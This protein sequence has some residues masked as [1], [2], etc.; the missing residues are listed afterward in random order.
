MAIAGEAS[1]SYRI[2]CDSGLGHA[3]AVWVLSKLLLSRGAEGMAG[4]FLMQGSDRQ[5]GRAIVD[6]PELT[7][8]KDVAEWVRECYSQAETI[9][10]YG[11]GGSTVMAS[12]MTGKTIFS[13]ESDPDWCQDMQAYFKRVGTNSEVHL[14][15]AD[16]GPVG[17]W[18]RPRSHKAW[19][20]YHLYPN[21]VW[22][23]SDFKAPDL[24]LVD[25]RFRTACFVTALLRTEKPVTVLFD[26]YVRRKAY[27]V[28]ERFA[29]PVEIRNRMARFDILP[30]ELPRHALSDIL[31]TY[32]RPF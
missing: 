7:F 22:D 1:K 31:A 30:T 26:D 12:E 4:D 11:S 18:G 10:E 2:Y 15:Y 16:I 27:H 25:G 19:A 3:A 21:S 8:P 28:V 5:A 24:V 17:K 14:H 9:L 32:T 29:E 23:R 20:Q 13:V 6:R